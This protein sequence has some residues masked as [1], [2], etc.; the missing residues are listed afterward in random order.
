MNQLHDTIEE[1]T[2]ITNTTTNRSISI[3]LTK[4]LQ[5]KSKLISTTSCKTIFFNLLKLM[6]RDNELIKYLIILCIDKL[7]KTKKL[8]EGFI[9]TSTLLNEI[10]K[11]TILRGRCLYLLYSLLD[12]NSLKEYNNLFNKI[13]IYNPDLVYLTLI[14]HINENNKN[15]YIEL[16]NQINLESEEM[17]L[18]HLYCLI[19]KIN[20][21]NDL[22]LKKR[23][24][25]S[26]GILQIR[27][28]NNEINKEINKENNIKKFNSGFNSIIEI[29]LE[30]CKKAL[31]NK[32]LINKKLINCLER[33][34]KNSLFQKSILFSMK[35]LDKEIL[36][37]F[38]CLI[39]NLKIIWEQ[40]KNEMCLEILLKMGETSFNLI[41]KSLS[42]KTEI[43]KSQKNT[44]NYV[45]NLIENLKSNSMILIT[46]D[47]IK[48]YL[49]NNSFIIN[50]TKVGCID[51]NRVTNDV[52]ALFSA[53]I[54]KLEDTSE[55]IMCEILCIL[56][57][58]SSKLNYK[59][60]NKFLSFI[61]NRL[62]L[63]SETVKRAACQSLF[64][65]LQNKKNINFEINNLLINFQLIDYYN[66]LKN[67]NFNSFEKI[68]I[69]IINKSSNKI[70]CNKDIEIMLE[71]TIT[72]EEIYL[73]FKIRNLTNLN[74]KSAFLKIESNSF[75]FEDFIENN[76]EFKIK[77]LPQMHEI[78][79]GILK[80]ELTDGDDIE[81]LNINL[82][83]FSINFADLL[84]N[85]KNANQ[86]NKSFEFKESICLKGNENEIKS[87]LNF[88][89]QVFNN[90]L[91]FIEFIS[92]NNNKIQINVYS[93]DLNLI[94]EVINIFN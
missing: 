33:N 86:F 4:I 69:E 18:Y 40:T 56:G 14:K 34:L 5:I 71:K 47:L 16:I 75:S 39:N 37:N 22:I 20:E 91:I 58:E 35:K 61:L 11:P 76:L 28:L 73:N 15:K 65:M 8:K 30:T 48:E 57:R 92:N 85:V 66:L 84:M 46:L 74:L 29:E 64:F 52:D 13:L 63:E 27:K 12:E 10:N 36:K 50:G 2:L 83:E 17:V 88:G 42:L 68:N 3:I 67:I 41:P 38:K 94:K 72:E 87:L 77:K 43:L 70:L 93:D 51:I 45:P 1:L 90:K 44:E 31:N 9:G 49:N 89:L 81:E 59:E 24:I 54:E 53:L 6:Q 21:N 26:C 23:Y 82:I 60:I 32:E 25:N 19:N 62:L 80:C 55:N 78:F 7:N 79:N